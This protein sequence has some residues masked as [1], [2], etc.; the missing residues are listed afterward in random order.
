MYIGASRSRREL[1]QAKILLNSAAIA[2]EQRRE[3][4]RQQSKRDSKKFDSSSKR[5]CN[6]EHGSNKKKYFGRL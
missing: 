6:S 5:S 4:E 3:R 1:E 2:D